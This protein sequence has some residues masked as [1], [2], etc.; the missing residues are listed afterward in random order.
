M[1]WLPVVLTRKPTGCLPAGFLCI[2]G[3]AKQKLPLIDFMNH[4]LEMLG[5]AFDGQDDGAFLNPIGGSGDRWN[6]LAAVGEA[7]A[8][9]EGAVGAKLDRFALETDLGGRF[10]GAVN[11]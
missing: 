4:R 3:I 9:G 5:I 6:N 8:H 10:G 11:D 7:E 1:S 2:G